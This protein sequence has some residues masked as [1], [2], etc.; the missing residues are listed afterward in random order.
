MRIN[1]VL[2]LFLGEPRAKV[3]FLDAFKSG[4]RMTIL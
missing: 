2:I 1:V 4:L 3:S